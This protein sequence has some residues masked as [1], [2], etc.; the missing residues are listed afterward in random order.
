MPKRI[1][2]CDGDEE[3]TDAHPETVCEG[4]D[5]EREDKVGEEGCYEN[6]EGF[7]GEEVEEEPEDPG[8]E[9]GCGGGE[10]GEPVGDDGEEDCYYDCIFVSGV[11]VKMGGIGIQRN[12]RPI[13]KLA[14]M[15]GVA[16]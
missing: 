13:M 16:P 14:R 3:P 10:V 2:N 6:D 12:G 7:G 5:C 15:N 1:E 8:E 4:D 9:G 11:I